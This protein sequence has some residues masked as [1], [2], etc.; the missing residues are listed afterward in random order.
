M[1]NKAAWLAIASLLLTAV[2]ITPH[3]ADAMWG[4]RDSGPRNPLVAPPSN[5]LPAAG[6]TPRAHYVIHGGYVAA[7]VG[8]RD[9]GFGSITIAGIPAGSKVVRA[10][11]YWDVL[12]DG[13][14][15]SLGVAKFN[16]KLIMG[17]YIGQ[18]GDPC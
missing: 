16:G 8:M 10:F 2:F 14:D 1:K 7:G 9:A 6:V 15:P 3:R 11:L 5:G 4:V 17:N 13:L 18:G 12:A